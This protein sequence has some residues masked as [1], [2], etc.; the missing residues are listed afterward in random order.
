MVIKVKV[1]VGGDEFAYEGEASFADLLPTLKQW[2]DL[3]SRDG[4][5]Q[6]LTARLR[7]DNDSLADAVQAHRSD[8]SQQ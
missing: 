1:T 5:L 8:P 7:K 4:A 2:L 3:Q 6:G